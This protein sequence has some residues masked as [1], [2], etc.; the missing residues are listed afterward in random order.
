MGKRVPEKLPIQFRFMDVDRAKIKPEDRTVELSFSSETPVERWWGTEVLSHDPGCVRMNRLRSGAAL[1]FNHDS[2]SQIGVVEEA[3]IDGDRVGRAVVRFGNGPLATEK[4]NDVK[5]GI[6]RNVSVGYIIHRY[7]SAKDGNGENEV[8]RVTD[9]EPVEITMCPVP[10]DP[11]VG[12][13]RSASLEYPV[14]N[15]RK[16]P[17]EQAKQEKVTMEKE[18][19]APSAVEVSV[20]EV[21]TQ[22]VA[23]VRGIQ[24]VAS[25]FTAQVRDGELAK[26]I[27]EGTAEGDVRKQIMDRVIEEKKENAVRTKPS[28][29]ISE[30]EQKPFNLMR[31]I[32]HFAA[33][34]EGSRGPDAGYELEVSAAMEKTNPSQRGGIVIPTNVPMFQRTGLDT[35]TNA[36]GA[37]SVQTTLQSLIELLRNR[38]VVRQAGATVL[39]GLSDTLAFPKQL[40]PGTA[41]W[42][43]E[44][45]GSDNTDA[46][47]TLGQITMSPKMLTSSTSYSRKL[48]A[49]SSID[50][51][52]LV[53]NDLVAINAL[54]LDLAA[55]NG[56]GSANQPTGILNTSNVNGITFATDG[57]APTYAHF[58]Q[59]ETLIAGLN[60]DIGEMAYVITPEVKGFGKQTAKVSG[61]LLG[62]IVESNGDINGYR[63]FV[64]NQLPKTLTRGNKSDCHAGVFGVWPFLLIG[65]WG[66][67]ELV[68]DPYAKKKQGMI[69]IASYLMADI[70]VRYPVAFSFSKYWTAS[71]L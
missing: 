20:N 51:E 22:E 36:A 8:D 38:M 41:N 53:R 55:L 4:F 50:I 40:T 24:A 49:Q 70:A 69:E 37:Y 15:D 39:S 5:D 65:E 1:L 45:P 59:M 28:L 18:T 25:Q 34:A 30:K 60:A 31:L 63:S 61:Q 46:D 64:T 11:N 35:K 12:V 57:A 6:L 67:I 21:R 27:N 42:V 33:R 26:W 10:A 9:W 32:Q 14:V 17:A 3:R 62:T 48:M 47:L 2:M 52:A 16:I 71:A 58:V 23:R 68:V 66:S 54:A 56:L 7:E 19:P 29:D 43:A 13:G 44:N